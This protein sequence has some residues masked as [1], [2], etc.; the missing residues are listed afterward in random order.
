MAGIRLRIDDRDLRRLDARAKDI[1][2]LAGTE[3][4]MDEI[5][6]ALVAWSTRNFELERAPDGTPWKKSRRALDEGGQT[7]TKSGRLRQSQTHV[8]GRSFAEAGNN[9]IYG[10][11][12]QLGATIVPRQA[13]ALVFQIGGQT[14]VAQKV[15]IPARPYMGIGGGD[16]E[17]EL[18]AIVGDFFDGRVG[19]EAR[20]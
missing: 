14:V 11:V 20:A 4:L 3:A 16:D 15:T 13:R 6:G 12:H 5:G 17:R 8:Y 2:R 9:L 19:G 7:L 1:G 10:G 18:A